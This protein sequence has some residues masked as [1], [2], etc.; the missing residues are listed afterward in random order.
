MICTDI[1]T[2]LKRWPFYLV[3]LILITGCS[4]KGSFQGL[5]SYFDR[6]AKMQPFIIQRPPGNICN[7][8]SAE[9]PIVYPI[10]GLDLRGCLEEIEMALVY[11][12]R[13]NC[14]SSVCISPTIAQVHCEK[15]S[16]ELFVVA[17]YYDYERMSFRHS[18]KRPVFGIDCH[19]YGNNLT[20]KYVTQF[21]S[22][23]VGVETMPGNYF[24]L[25]RKGSLISVAGSLDKIQFPAY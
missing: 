7:L 20:K 18:T 23:L 21:L 22:D 14:S 5:Y 6:T 4:V 11:I 9:A 16:I 1:P 2:F 24:F 15:S 8:L 13:P 12:W 10:N 25:F 3:F 17:E 19:F